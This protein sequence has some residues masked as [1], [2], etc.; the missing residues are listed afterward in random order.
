MKTVCLGHFGS[1]ENSWSSELLALFI[2][3]HI[4]DLAS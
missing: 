2:H 3:F 1:L 4:H